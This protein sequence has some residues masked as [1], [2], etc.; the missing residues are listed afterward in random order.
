MLIHTYRLIVAA[1][2]CSGPQQNLLRQGEPQ[3]NRREFRSGGLAAVEY[4]KSGL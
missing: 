2:G 3:A 4:R 1:Y